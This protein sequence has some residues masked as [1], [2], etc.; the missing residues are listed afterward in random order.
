MNKSCVLRN[1]VLIVPVLGEPMFSLSSQEHY[2]RQARTED[3]RNAVCSGIPIWKSNSF[4]RTITL[5]HRSIGFA[6]SRHSP[7]RHLL[8]DISTPS[9]RYPGT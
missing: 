6:A 5:K 1:L 4:W 8:L 7:P 2:T 9:N 3:R